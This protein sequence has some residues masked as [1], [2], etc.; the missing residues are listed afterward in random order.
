MIA[1]FY[2]IAQF[3]VDPN[4]SNQKY[5]VNLFTIQGEDR[6]YL[7]TT[8]WFEFEVVFKLNS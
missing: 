4:R 2:H 8:Y 1:L 7:I 3:V 5:L 6:L